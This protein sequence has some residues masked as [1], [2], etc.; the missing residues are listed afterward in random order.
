[1]TTDRGQQGFGL[2]FTIGRGNDIG[3]YEFDASVDFDCLTTILPRTEAII[4]VDL[5]L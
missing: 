1:V 3:R 5:D 2:T 4:A